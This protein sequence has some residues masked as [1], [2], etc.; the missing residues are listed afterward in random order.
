MGDWTEITK[1]SHWRRKKDGKVV[2]VVE[3][4][5]SRMGFVCL[6]WPPSTGNGMI[7]SRRTT[8]KRVHYFLGEFDRP[9]PTAQEGEDG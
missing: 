8:R 4:P 5:R 2:E 7:R 6:L 9:D 1:G 3:A